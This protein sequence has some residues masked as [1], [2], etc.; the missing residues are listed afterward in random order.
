VKSGVANCKAQCFVNDMLEV[1]GSISLIISYSI[2]LVLQSLLYMFL[3]GLL[4]GGY[5]T[6]FI[7]SMFSP[8]PISF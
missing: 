5:Q 7:Q 3:R 6:S 4:E 1:C 8:N 2:F